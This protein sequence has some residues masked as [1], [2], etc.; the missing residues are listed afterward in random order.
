M[1]LDIQAE[2]RR[3]IRRT[4]ITTGIAVLA[5]L[6]AAIV[7]VLVI[8]DGDEVAVPSQT[9][10][11]ASAPT[12]PGT[13]ST[14]ASG[15]EFGTVTWTDV[16]GLALPVSARNGPAQTASGRAARFSRDRPGAVLAAVHISARAAAVGGPAVYRPTIDEQVVGPDA[17]ELLA[18]VESDYEQR[19]IQAGL[20]LGEPLPD[21]QAALAGYCIDSATP[22]A[23]SLRLLMS[24]PGTAAQG[25]IYVAFRLEVR[26]TDRDWRL[27]A[28]PDGQ[29]SNN[30]TQ[31]TATTGYTP[32][33]GR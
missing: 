17:D 25:V 4:V 33:P 7:T 10:S 26:W 22:S 21:S 5:V 16:H 13:S 28:P 19:R 12:G 3:R 14:S 30:T 2:T 24:S 9:A 6:A 27:L 29:W 32:F 15:D 11:S 8:R 31:V 18:N 23:V 1:T 20:A